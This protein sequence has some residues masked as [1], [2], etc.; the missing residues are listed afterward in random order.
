MPKVRVGTDP[1]CPPTFRM[2]KK[3]LNSGWFARLALSVA[4]VGIVLIFTAMSSAQ[5]ASTLP[6]TTQPVLTSHDPFAD[7]PSYGDM[8]RRTAYT[9]LAIIIA[10]ILAAKFIPRLFGRGAFAPRGRMIQVVERHA[11]EP[12]KTVYLIKVADQ[13]FLIGATGDRLE[14]LAGGALDQETVRQRLKELEKPKEAKAARP[15]PEPEV[16][17]TEVLRGK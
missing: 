2:W 16:S 1:T 3:A 8:I 11:L 7:L 14:T 12:R 15:R 4:L 9:L 10:F 17:F 6:V 5:Q 13:Y